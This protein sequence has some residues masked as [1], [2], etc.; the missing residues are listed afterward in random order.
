MINNDKI[1]FRPTNLSDESLLA[2]RENSTIY[3]E[4]YFFYYFRY[5]FRTNL[6]IAWLTH[7]RD[8]GSS[9]NKSKLML[10]QSIN[11]S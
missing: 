4:V 9:V 6:Q 10:K 8:G 2:I 1:N 5:R 3:R 7:W 11:A